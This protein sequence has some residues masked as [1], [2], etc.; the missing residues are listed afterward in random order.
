MASTYAKALARAAEKEFDLYGSFHETT[1]LMQRRIARYWSD[2]GLRFPGVGVAWS[3]VFVSAQVKGA[4]ATAREFK[5]AAAHSQF[6][7]AAAKNAANQSGVFRAF[8]VSDY[9]PKV[10]DIIQNNRNGNAFTFAYARTHQRYQSHSAVV[11]EEGADGS[12][13]YVRTIG[14]NEGDRVGEKVLRLTARGIVKQPV[15]APN[16]YIAIIQNL[17]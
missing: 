5:F 15:S 12:G 14:G 17:K 3:A 11:V 10:G 4:G 2:I 9:A 6:V 7:F 8:A 1:S 16:Y 13:R